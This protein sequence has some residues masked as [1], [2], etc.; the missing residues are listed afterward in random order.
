MNIIGD[1]APPF[2]TAI[3]KDIHDHSATNNKFWKWRGHFKFGLKFLNVLFLS[4]NKRMDFFFYIY[5]NYGNTIAINC[6]VLH[7]FI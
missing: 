6:F 4:N 5:I 7:I 2:Q 3:F 1:G